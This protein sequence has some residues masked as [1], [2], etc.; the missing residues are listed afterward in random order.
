MHTWH[1]VTIKKKIDKLMKFA[2]CEKL[3]VKLSL[4]EDYFTIWNGGT[5]AKTDLEHLTIEE[6]KDTL[7]TLKDTEGKQIKIQNETLD[8]EFSKCINPDWKYRNR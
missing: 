5:D 8:F 3:Y 7:E 4:D 6:A 1:P 2:T